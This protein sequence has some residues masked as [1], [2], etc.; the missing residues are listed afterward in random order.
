MVIEDLTPSSALRCL[1]LQLHLRLLL[2]FLL[3]TSFSPSSLSS[4]HL[5]CCGFHFSPSLCLCWCWFFWILFYVSKDLT[6]YLHWV[7]RKL[8]IFELKM[9]KCFNHYIFSAEPVM[10]LLIDWYVTSIWWLST[11][12]IDEYKRKIKLS[13]KKKKNRWGHH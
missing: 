7:R 6:C 12:S 3:L 11:Q 9:A 4:F 1:H 2:L 5:H 10:W 13:K 8:L